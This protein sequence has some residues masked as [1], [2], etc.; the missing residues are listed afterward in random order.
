MSTDDTNTTEAQVE[1]RYPIVEI[2]RLTTTRDRDGV[3]L[4]VDVDV[5]YF[6]QTHGHELELRY[7]VLES[8]V[9]ELVRLKPVSSAPRSDEIVPFFPS[10]LRVLPAVEDALERVPGIERAEPVDHTLG[11]HLSVGEA[12][13]YEE[14]IDGLVYR[15]DTEGDR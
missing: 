6:E 7:D 10:Q 9:A 15:G 12:D 11:D 1:D 14:T 2:R 4:R 13:V 3:P 8:G 5:E